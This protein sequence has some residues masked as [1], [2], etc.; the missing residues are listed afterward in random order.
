V[1]HVTGNGNN[2]N[3]VQVAVGC[4]IAHDDGWTGFLDFATERRVEI[5]HQISPRSMR[6]REGGVGD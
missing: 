3:A 1:G 5:D 2:L 6:F 4:A